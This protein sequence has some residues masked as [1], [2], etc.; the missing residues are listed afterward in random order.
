VTLVNGGVV[1]ST[2]DISVVFDFIAEGLTGSGGDLL[3]GASGAMSTFERVKLEELASMIRTTDGA[4]RIVLMQEYNT[5]I[6]NWSDSFS[7]AKSLIDI[8]EA[9]DTTTLTADKK[10]AMTALIDTLLV[11]DAASTDEITLASKLIQ[12]LIPEGSANRTSILEKLTL[13]SSH[14][15]DITANKKLGN[16]ILDLVKDDTTIEDKYKLHIR[17]Q[18]R[19]IINGGQASTPSAEV[20]ETSATGGGMLGFISGVVWIFVYII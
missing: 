5:M 19:I 17:N 12:D 13:I 16:E 8:Q 4:D 3:L 9:I 15:S 10:S 7:K 11:G 1:T 20:E 14:P 18:L 2:R 6:E